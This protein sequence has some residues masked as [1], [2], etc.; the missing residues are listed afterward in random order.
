MKL[1]TFLAL[2]IAFASSL[3]N[4]Q[5]LTYALNTTPIKAGVLVVPGQDN[6]W[7]S[8]AQPVNPRPFVW[9]ALDRL[10]S[11][12]PAN[13][14]FVNPRANTIVS[15]AVRTRFLALGYSNVAPTGSRLERR[16]A[17]YWE[18]FLQNTSDD[19]LS[20]YDAL[21]LGI[22]G[23]LSLS[24]RNREKLRRYVDQGGFLWIDIVGTSGNGVD[25]VNPPPMPFQLFSSTATLEWNIDHPLLNVPNLVSDGELGGLFGASGYMFGPLDAGAL[26][27]IE[28]IQSWIEAD[29]SRYQAIV[30]DSNGRL[31]A[32]TAQLGDG[33]LLITGKGIGGVVSD[34]QVG[35]FYMADPSFS[36]AQVAAAKFAINAINLNSAFPSAGRGSRKTNSTSINLTAPLLRRFKQAEVPQGA[37]QSAVFYK[38]RVILTAGSQIIVKDANPSVDLDNDGNPDDGLPDAVPGEGDMLWKSENLAGPISAPVAVEIPDVNSPADEILVVDANGNL[39]AFPLDPPTSGNLNSVARIGTATPD[40]AGQPGTAFAPTIHEGI[41]YITDT[42]TRNGLPVGRIWAVDIRSMK[43]IQSAN[44][45]SVDGASRM[46]APSGPATVGYISIQDNS[47]GLDRVAYVPTTSDTTTRRPCGLASVWIGSRGERPAAMVRSGNTLK[48]GTRASLNGLP[49]Y[50]P[51]G[52]SPYGVKITL[53]DPLT[54]RPYTTSEMANV[55]ANAAPQDGD[56]PG[57]INVQLG[58]GASG[59]VFDD[60]SAANPTVAL[61]IDYTI[62][63]G[64]RDFNGT[65]IQPEAFVR[66]DLRF[67]DENLSPRRKVL[68]NIAMAGNG[69]IFVVTGTGGGVSASPGGSMMCFR[70]EG[71]GDFRMLYRWELYDTFTFPLTNP[72]GTAQDFKY[73]PA[74]ID[75]DGVIDLIQPA[76]GFRPLD[77]E[78]QSLRFSSGPTVRGNTVYVMAVGQKKF[79][80][81]ALDNLGD[82]TTALL[83]FD[84]NPPTPEILLENLN[85]SFAVVQPDTA[86]SQ[87]KGKPE[88]LSAL[89]PGQ[90]TFEQLVPDKPNTG[91]L[92]ID[93]MMTVKRGQIRDSLAVN[94]PI[95]VRTGGQ[96]DII[97]EPEAEAKDGAIVPG[98]AR[99]RWNPLKWQTVFNGMNAFTQPVVNG[100]TIYLG[101]GSLLPG[102]IKFGFNINQGFNFQGLLYGINVQ[103]S[104]SDLQ[105][106]IVKRSWMKRSARPWQ[107][108][109][110]QV[111]VTPADSTGGNGFNRAIIGSPYVLWPQF[112]GIKTGD[113]FA[114]RLGQA[115]I[116]DSQIFG[117]T[118]GE[119]VLAVWGNS[120]LYAFSRGDFLVADENRILR[121]DAS[122]NPL[123]T[124]ENTR[125]SGANGVTGVDESSIPI[126]KPWRVY[127]SGNN[128]YWMVD[129]G[130]DRIVRIDSA[131]RELRSIT[132][133]KVD[134]NWKPDGYSNNEPLKLRLPRDI[135]TYT[136]VERPVEK[137]GRNAFTNRQDYEF[138]QHYV[139]ADM[140]NYRAIELVDRYTYNPQRRQQGE[141]ISYAD[142]GSDKPG[143]LEKA[144]GVLWWHTRSDLSGRGFAYNS[145]GRVSY[146]DN[147]TGRQTPVFAFGFANAEPS[148]S[149]FGLTSAEPEH[150][151]NASGNGGIVVYDPTK[152]A[153]NVVNHYETSAIDAP[154]WDN[155]LGQDVRVQSPAQTE[156]HFRGLTSVTMRFVGVPDSNGKVI[157]QLRIMVTDSTGVYE[158]TPKDPAANTW[159]CTWMLPVEVSGVRS[160]DGANVREPVYASM[161]RFLNNQPPLNENPLGFRPL[162]ARRLD[163]GQILVVNGYIGRTRGGETFNGEIVLIKGEN[164]TSGTGYGFGWNKLNLGFNTFIVDFE[165]PPVQGVRGI[166]NPVFADRR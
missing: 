106:Q 120:A 89:Q 132:S 151:A 34:Q 157:A 135:A 119:G 94:L 116:E 95:V 49:V 111:T 92:R 38:G 75:Y 148:A 23:Q 43:Q 51:S 131:G 15:D 146:F 159:A 163:S 33:T 20:Q 27:S 126:S 108:V 96:S 7:A 128:A 130:N 80:F 18:V 123:W 11:V 1:K 79:G 107:K 152:G 154:F 110:S 100:D 114:V 64:R 127:P 78:I 164:D 76:P 17:G 8:N 147:V 60:Q 144:I 121:S 139:I 12:K 87:T 40:K 155:T 149:S 125:F 3:A 22:G 55:F 39:V 52:P 62:D 28:L 134:P 158:L 24:A 29:S 104:P 63:W 67:P 93:N 109:L 153:V 72:S 46:P 101:G 58:P 124:L 71:R 99:G 143:Q 69:N 102:F 19:V 91:R 6:N 48:I 113:D 103:V 26:G 81:S 5:P 56:A 35:N 70:E 141:L 25:I 133:M 105:S 37:N 98:S 82:N 47:G 36:A 115:V 57:W 31:A 86:R 10:R 112:W 16:Q 66:G 138:W 32:A 68:G 97:I 136:T 129:A 9:A 137:G 65:L 59:L 90:F 21:Y 30:R 14:T 2:G 117:I 140:G 54:Q 74:I 45:W 44:G 84:A 162:Y 88:V 122:G 160:T 166:V 61:R 83:A 156:R 4:A 142:P 150:L 145:I 118:G 41:A 165:L 73:D 53:L 161:R 85:P 42:T 77:R 13:W 50:L